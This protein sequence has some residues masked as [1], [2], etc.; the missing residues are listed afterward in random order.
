M[1]KKILVICQHF[2]PEEFR[3][4]DITKSL[5]EL[6]YEVDVICGIPN[7][8][9]GKCFEGY[10]LFKQRQEEYEGVK[11]Y[12][13]FL[14][15]RGSGNALQVLLNYITFPIFSLLQLFKLRKRNYD[16]IMVYQLTPVFMAFPALIAR[17]MFKK[18]TYLYILDLWPESL[19]SVYNYNSSIYKV[20]F[21]KISNSLYRRFDYFMTTSNGIKS[22]IQ[23]RYQIS[24]NRVLYLPNW[25]EEIY[26]EKRQDPELQNKFAGTFNVMFAGNIGPAQSFETIIMAAKVCKDN[27]YTNIKWIIVGDGMTRKWA[28]DRASEIGVAEVMDFVGRKPMANMPEYYDVASVMLVSLVKS[29]LFSITLPAKIQSYLAA[30]KPILA[31]LD[32][33]GGMIIAESNSGLV[34]ASED[35]I[36]LAENVKKMSLLTDDELN[37]LGT[38]GYEYYRSNFRKNGLIKKLTSFMFNKT[39]IK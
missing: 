4:N 15:P 34:S 33:E 5:V 24:E 37:Q 10:S 36:S 39:A 20:L 29:E 27:G 35:Y 3:I 7:Y 19:F 9:Q 16:K 18:E 26:E 6:G 32:G 12:R 13:S 30:G 21:T 8:P 22:L 23:E 25:A 17:R 14:I 2:W 1:T 11:V 38:N 31:S 28:E